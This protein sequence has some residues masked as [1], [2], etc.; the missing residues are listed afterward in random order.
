MTYYDTGSYTTMESLIEAIR[1]FVGLNGWSQAAYSSDG[2]GRRLHI[3]RN[4]QY[5][6]IRSA[7]AEAPFS[8][9][10]SRTITGLGI[11]GS[12]GNGGGNWDAQAGAGNMSGFGG[13]V[14]DLYNSGSHTYHLFAPDNGD[15]IFLF[16]GSGDFTGRLDDQF[17]QMAFGITSIGLPFYSASADFNATL[18]AVADKNWW[19]YAHFR[20]FMF[21]HY[22]SH[23]E[24]SMSVMYDTDLWTDQTSHSVSISGMT[25]GQLLRP[26]GS[27]Y[28]SAY[29]SFA[30][31]LVNKSQGG[32]RGN[33]MLIPT[34]MFYRKHTG[35]RHY[36][37]HIPDCF[38]MN[39]MKHYHDEDVIS[40]GG[41]D[42]MLTMPFP[43][44]DESGFTS[45]LNPPLA[46]TA[47]AVRAILP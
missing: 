15:Q 28:I 22:A 13:M 34:D 8:G 17:R 35:E 43:E 45:G 26:L 7:V 20:S 2:T 42:Y 4:G 37:G 40:I 30:S 27:S 36:A 24:Y 21:E 6:N 3:H 33:P 12:T 46:Q 38:M 41:D 47:F 9:A 16:V 18:P 5:I 32:L 25:A 31:Y 39:T 19:S 29:A 1:I 10:N 11:N 44:A 14:P 23:G